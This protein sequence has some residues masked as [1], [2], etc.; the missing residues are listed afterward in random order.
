MFLGTGSAGGQV[1]PIT[2]ATTLRQRWAAFAELLNME[3]CT[4]VVFDAQIALMACC[5][6]SSTGA[7]RGCAADAKN[8][9]DPKVLVAKS[10]YLLL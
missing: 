2:C 10:L 4:K 7:P 9:F 3:D 8:L 5:E 1:L 6:G